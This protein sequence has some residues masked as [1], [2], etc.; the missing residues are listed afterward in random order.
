MKMKEK[1][2]KFVSFY[3][4]NNN[5]IEGY[6]EIL[7]QSNVF[8]KLKTST[9]ILTIPFHRVLKIKEKIEENVAN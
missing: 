9:N 7:E 1:K 5:L 8:V 4:E 2:V 6:F 3:D